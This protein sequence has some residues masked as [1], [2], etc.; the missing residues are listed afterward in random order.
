MPLIL[1]PLKKKLP[2]MTLILSEEMTDTLLRRLQNHEIDAALLAT[3]VEAPDCRR[4]RSS[5]NRSGS[6]IHANIRS[7][8]RIRS[9][10]R[11][12]AVRTCCY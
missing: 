6:P 3:P 1:S 2:Q 8:I 9:C 12:F 10:S 4:L 11:I 7:T 5:M